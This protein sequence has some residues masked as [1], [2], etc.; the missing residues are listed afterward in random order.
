MKKVDI[1]KMYNSKDEY[2][3]YIPDC[4]DTVKLSDINIKTYEGCVNRTLKKDFKP[5][6]VIDGKLA[7]RGRYYR[8]PECNQLLPGISFKLLHKSNKGKD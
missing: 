8:C 7:S 3:V 2:Y 4:G 6:K 5:L 1:E